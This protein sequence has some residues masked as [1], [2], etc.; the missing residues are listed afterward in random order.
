MKK[1]NIIAAVCLTAL[2]FLTGAATGAP[3]PM[4]KAIGFDAVN[5]NIDRITFKLNGAHLPSTFALKGE[6]PR[7]VFDF[8]DTI[9][10]KAVKNITKTDGTFVTQIRIGI[11]R[12]K[13]AKTRVVFDLASNDPVDFKQDF[14][15]ATNTLVISVFKPGTSLTSSDAAAPPGLEEGTRKS[16]DADQKMMELP[17]P[18]ELPGQ[19]TDVPPHAQDLMPGQ[20]ETAPVMPEPEKVA[21]PVTPHPGLEPLPETAPLPEPKPLP[22]ADTQHDEATKIQPLSEIGNK[23]TSAASVVPMLNSIEFDKESNRGEMLIFKLNSFN[24]PVVFGIEE[25]VPRIVC[26]FKDTRAGEQL[27]DLINSDGRFVK[28]IKV[29]KYHN[30]DNIRVVLDLVPEHNYDLQQVFFKED[31]MFMIIIDSAGDKLP[32]PGL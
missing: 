29:A 14:D 15:A 31:N 13:N 22:S 8:P 1:L 11:H 16:A 30:P 6:R 18:K 9:P 2:L 20:Q 4:L 28:S 26:F 27:R 32:S 10:T 7:V 3:R 12:G 23:E 21:E 25:D 5:P 24:P 17:E 19:T